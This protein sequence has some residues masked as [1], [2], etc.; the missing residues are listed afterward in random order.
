MEQESIQY[1][2]QAASEQQPNKPAGAID[3]IEALYDIAGDYLDTRL[4]LLRMKSTLKASDLISSIASA[5]FVIIFIL[6]I[7]LFLNFGLGY[8]LGDL[9][10]KTSYGFF[11]L[12][13]FYLLVGT[14]FYFFR[15]RLVK[16]P[17]ANAVIRKIL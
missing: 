2:E 9:L 1:K 11:A 6:T 4:D 12:A 13:G 10:G 5:A 14:I 3:N 7:F 15:N 16:T 8:W 17:V